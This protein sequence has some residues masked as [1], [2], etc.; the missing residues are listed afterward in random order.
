MVLR[1]SGGKVHAC[2]DPAGEGLMQWSPGALAFP[3]AP[4][5][6]IDCM[7]GNS[8]GQEQRADRHEGSA[9]VMLN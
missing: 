9:M 5:L 1:G 6:T 3:L 4:F 7:C 8:L 2:R